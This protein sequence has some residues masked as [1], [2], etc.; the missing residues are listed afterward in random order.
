MPY[1]AKTEVSAE[2]S[3][4]EITALLRKYNATG[5]TFGERA[6]YAFLEFDMNDRRV[7]FLVPL[8]DRADY[9]YNS[10]QK[11]RAE[12]A[13]QKDFEQAIRSRWRALYAVVKAKMIAVEENIVSFD[14]EFLPHFVTNANKTV[15][16]VMQPDL[17]KLNASGLPA[18]M[19]GGTSK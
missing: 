12:T 11:R 7:R 15:F 8:P 9:I 5:F 14:Q 16:E 3:V 4:Q 6:G 10:Y 19:P 1:A 17:H 18:L 13:I 2:K